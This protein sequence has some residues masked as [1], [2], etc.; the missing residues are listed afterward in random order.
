MGKEKSRRS[1]RAE[2][3]AVFSVYFSVYDMR[4]TL[5]HA[6]PLAASPH[7]QFK[8][9]AVSVVIVCV[10]LFSILPWSVSVSVSSCEHTRQSQSWTKCSD[11]KY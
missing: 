11:L 7:L 5:T 9:I 10:H 3:R 2:S 6:S 4:G 8:Y 1:G